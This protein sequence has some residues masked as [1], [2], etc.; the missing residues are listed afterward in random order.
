V[1]Q[2]RIRVRYREFVGGW[3][4]YMLVSKDEIRDI[5][6]GT[7]WKLSRTIDSGGPDYVAVIEKIS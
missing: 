1:G 4:D 6:E 7:N 5:L 2:V 3:F